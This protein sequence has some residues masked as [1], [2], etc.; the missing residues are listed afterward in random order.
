MTP[1]VPSTTSWCSWQSC[2]RSRTPSTPPPAPSRRCSTRCG[3]RCSRAAAQQAAAAT[4]PRNPAAL[5]CAWSAALCST[6]K[7]RALCYRRCT[8]GAGRQGWDPA[9]A[10]TA[11]TPRSP[12]PPSS[13]CARPARCW[14]CWH[15]R[16][17]WCWTAAA[18]EEDTLAAATTTLLL[19]RRLPA[20]RLRRAA[21]VPPSSCATF[22]RSVP[23][24]TSRSPIL[25]SLLQ[26]AAWQPGTG[27][28]ERL[29]P[30]SG[31]L[32]CTG[33]P[34]RLPAGGPR[35]P[36]GAAD[37]RPGGAPRRRHGHRWVTGALESRFS[38]CSFFG[39]PGP[40]AQRGVRIR[41]VRC[42]LP[43]TCTCSQPPCSFTSSI[44]HCLPTP[45]S[46]TCRHPQGG[47]LRLFHPLSLRVARRAPPAAPLAGPPHRQPACHLRQARQWPDLKWA[48]FRWRWWRCCCCCSAG[49]W[50]AVL[51][52]SPRQWCRCTLHN[53]LRPGKVG[54]AAMCLCGCIEVRRRCIAAALQ[55]GRSGL[56][57]A[58]PG[59]HPCAA[60]GVAL[61][62]RIRR[63]LGAV[64]VCVWGWGGGGGGGRSTEGSRGME[65]KQVGRKGGVHRQPG[66]TASGSEGCER[67]RFF[68]RREF[69]E[70]GSG[71]N[72]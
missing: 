34:G 10:Y 6:P 43:A 56:L 30:T 70:G 18:E 65:A 19:R 26:Q 66:T 25:V 38:A 20:A 8:C 51:G 45:R 29:L 11:S 15:G 47:L 71:G 1:R 7:R 40:G 14:R 50:L 41:N 42:I 59:C 60:V 44:T 3:R 55:A 64:C 57:Q 48:V 72:R 22:V 13:K 52:E 68:W 23:L 21:V 67:A 62:Q 16:G 2:T 28:I 5:M 31:L 17:G 46:P 39:G 36:G 63:Q 49:C 58:A 12:C 54:F 35:Q 53:L 27:T 61:Q 24:T 69:G 32:V 37:L 4:A 33:Q 9:S